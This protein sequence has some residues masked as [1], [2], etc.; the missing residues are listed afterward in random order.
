LLQELQIHSGWR[1]YIQLFLLGDILHFASIAMIIL[2]FVSKVPSSRHV[3]L[4]IAAGICLLSPLFW[5]A[6]CNNLIVNYCF[7]LF[8]GQPP[9]VFFPLLPW[10]VYPL[11]G[12]YLGRILQKKDQWIGFDSFWIIGLGFLITASLLK[13]FLHDDSLSSFYRTT[14]L[15]TILHVGFALI[16]LSAWHWISRNVK[17]NILFQ[18]FTY[19]SRNIT[20]IYIIQW[21]VICWLLPFTGYQKTGF[22]GS[23]FLIILTLTITFFISLIINISKSM[24]K[25]TTTFLL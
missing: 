19:A 11:L 13:Y 21:I 5:D 9:R 25:M 18:L 4:Y 8:G 2:F 10:L 14:P 6:S 24:T 3:E 16:V 22:I 1:G 20:Q 17:A 15:D 12:F 7:H 23:G